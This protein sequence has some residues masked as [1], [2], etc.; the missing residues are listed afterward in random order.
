[1]P[2][3]QALICRRHRF[4]R[5]RSRS[6]TARRLHAA[7]PAGSRHEVLDLRRFEGGPAR[8]QGL[9]AR[10]ARTGTQGA[11]RRRDRRGRGART[12]NGLLPRQGAWP[13][14]RRRRREGLHRLRQCRPQHDDH[15]LE[16]PAARQH[17]LLRVVD[18]A[19]GGPGAGLQLQCDGKPA[20][21]PQS[22]PLGCP[23]RCL[24]AARQ[25]HAA[26]RRR[27]RIARHGWRARHGAVPRLQQRALSHSGRPPAATPS[28]GALRAAPT[29]AASIFSRIPR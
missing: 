28:P 10:L 15:P 20:R 26:C 13:D 6:K 14:E 3:D 22:L 12:G 23:A 18:E 21:R 25:C 19:L 8:R 2:N 7:R 5:R 16:L 27:C 24:R 17:A 1:M 11:L 4:P 29:V 9:D